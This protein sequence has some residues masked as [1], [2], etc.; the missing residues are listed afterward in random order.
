MTDSCDYCG[1]FGDVYCSDPYFQDSTDLK[2]CPECLGT[3]FKPMRALRTE[4]D[5]K[6]A[7]ELAV[8]AVEQHLKVRR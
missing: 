3:G 8:K 6:K 4:S 1:G 2:S 7:L 5:P